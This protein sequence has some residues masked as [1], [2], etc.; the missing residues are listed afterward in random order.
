V[1]LVFGA[2]SGA[3]IYAWSA[4]SDSRAE[5]WTVAVPGLAT[6]AGT[7]MLALATVWTL[8]AAR[9]DRELER[10]AAE[11][12]E[13]RREARKVGV[14]LQ[15]RPADATFTVFN[16]GEQPILDVL[17][18]EPS[19]A[20]DHEGVTYEWKADLLTDMWPGVWFEHSLRTPF[21]PAGG[22]F[23]ITGNIYRIDAD[24]NTSAGRPG[25]GQRL[26]TQF[27]IAWTDWTDR[28]WVKVGQNE[29]QP[30]D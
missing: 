10:Q 17:V 27:R 2:A 6:G 8:R 22:H 3:A 19:T 24:K 30:T 16:A 7:L 23:G 12:V 15:H 28:K 4:T 18:V 9:I 29:P 21:V 11:E 13:V 25:D 14:M 20:P 1:V 5:F 26:E